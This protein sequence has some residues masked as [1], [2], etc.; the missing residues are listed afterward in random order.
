MQVDKREMPLRERGGISEA[1]TGGL[2]RC[3]SNS[4]GKADVAADWDSTDGYRPC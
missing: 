2:V 1:H 4:E 3:R